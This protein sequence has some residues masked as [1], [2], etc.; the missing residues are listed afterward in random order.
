MFVVIGEPRVP[1]AG[2]GVDP[3][4][5]MAPLWPSCA[6]ANLPRYFVALTRWP[7]FRCY[8]ASSPSASSRRLGIEP[9]CIFFYPALYL[10]N[11]TYIDA[12]ADSAAVLA[13]L[14][15]L[16]PSGRWFVVSWLLPGDA[17]SP[18]TA[19]T[20]LFSYPCS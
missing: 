14:P 6:V 5:L 8:I 19:S 9:L 2:A 17:F 13:H 20:S 7:H 16:P 10:Q 15:P 1:P 12:K 18:N 4:W 11:P 3:L